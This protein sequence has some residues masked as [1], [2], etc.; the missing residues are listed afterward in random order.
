MALH[1]VRSLGQ[2]FDVCHKLNPRPKKKKL[3]SEEKKQK[4]DEQKEEVEVP[5]EDDVTAVTASEQS[6]NTAQEPIASS[7]PFAPAD[8]E[9][10]PLIDLDPLASFNLPILPPG[11]CI[12]MNGMLYIMLLYSSYWR[13]INTNYYSYFYICWQTTS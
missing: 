5:K 4:E 3:Q 7:N 8:T 13:N 6:V 10:P 2:A 12:Y 9:L 11:N 1:V